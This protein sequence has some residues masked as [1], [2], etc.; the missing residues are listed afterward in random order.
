MRTRTRLATLAAVAA[1]SAS[2]LIGGTT[3]ISG[4]TRPAGLP[5]AS[6]G[7]PDFSGVWQA[8]NTANWDIQAHGAKRGPVVASGAAFGVPAGPG[9]VEGDE[10][11]YTPAAAAKKKENADNWLARDPEIKCYLPG[12]PRMMYMPYPLQIVQGRDAILIA[13]EFA[14][15]SR[16]VRMNSSEKSPTDTWMGWSIGH[17]EGD[18]LVIVVTDQNDQTWFDR[19]GDHHTEQLKVTE[20]YTMADKNTIT[21][22]ATM[23]DP[24]TFTRPWKI[25]FPLY[26]HLET[27]AQLLEYKCVEFVEELMWGHLRKMPTN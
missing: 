4:Q 21:Y 7:K 8:M 1:T 16:T 10:I 15:A 2:F 14:S 11:P 20:R 12:V 13:S 24:G 18:S 3:P 17:W 19:A 9:I 27:N 22:E 6:D 26:R 5:R 25:T 23:E